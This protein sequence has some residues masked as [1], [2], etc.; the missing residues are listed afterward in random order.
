MNIQDSLKK[1]VRAGTLERNQEIKKLR[2]DGMSF[3]EIG[4]KY[5]LSRERPRQIIKLSTLPEKH[6]RGLT[7]ILI[8]LLRRT[9]WRKFV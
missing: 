8:A 1:Q 9:L 6:H 2:A 7:N 4:R 3:A 5:N